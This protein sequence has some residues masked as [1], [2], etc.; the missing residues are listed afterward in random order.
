MSAVFIT[1]LWHYLAARVIYEDLLRPLG[2]GDPAPLLTVG[3][4]AVV[5][6]TLGRLS[7]TRGQR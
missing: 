3:L 7:V 2:H 4:V 5:A 1:Y 6:F